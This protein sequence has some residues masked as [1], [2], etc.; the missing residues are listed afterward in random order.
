MTQCVRTFG[1]RKQLPVFSERFDKMRALRRHQQN[2]KSFPRGSMKNAVSSVFRA[3][4]RGRH[5]LFAAALL[6]L[7]SLASA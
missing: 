1:I 6:S 4:R 3:A 5:A 7:S 2:D